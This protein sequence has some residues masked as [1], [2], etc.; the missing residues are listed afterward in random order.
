MA[1]NFIRIAT[2]M[3]RAARD[4]A[5]RHAIGWCLTLAVLSYGCV[6]AAHRPA[7]SSFR[8]EWLWNANDAIRAN[9]YLYFRKSITLETN[10]RS[11]LVHITADSRYKLYVNGHFVGR[12]PVRSDQRRQYYDSYDLA[13]FLKKGENVIAAIIHQYGVATGSY[14]LG[15]GGFWLQG[16]IRDTNDRVVRVDTD[17]SW[18]VL[19]ATAWEP[20]V[21]QISPAI[22]WMEIYDAR[23][24]P[25]GWQRPGYDDTHWQ[26][27]K[28]LGKPPV[29]P[30]KE[31]VPRDIPLL[32]EEERF[33]T[34]VLDVG[35]V[36][37]APQSATLRL[38][39]IF[40]TANG[41][42]AY[43]LSYLY[44]SVDQQ[45]SLSVHGSRVPAS[46][47]VWVN[48]FP[49][50]QQ[51]PSGNPAYRA[52][53][54]FALK[55]G[56]NEV[57]IKVYRDNPE[58]VVT[59]TLGP[60]DGRTFHPVQWYSEPRLGSP[61]NLI[62]IAGP[63]GNPGDPT[64]VITEI[65]QRTLSQSPRTHPELPGRV[66]SLSFS[67]NKN[68]AVLMA[69]ETRRSGSQSRVHDVDK[70]LAVNDGAASLSALDHKEGVYLTLDFGKEIS[71]YV[72]LRMKGVS[73][74]I[75]DLGYSEALLNGHVDTL[76]GELPW[77]FAD[78]Y[79]MR[80]G[81]QEWEL[82]FWKG[83]RYLQ[84]TFRQLER[85]IEIESVSLLFTSY[86]VHYR[87][88]FES[89]DSLLNQI[90]E[91]GRWTLQLCMHDAYED[92]PWREQSQWVGDAQVE[93][94]ANY[95]TFGDVALGSKYLRQIAQGQA[96]DGKLPAAYPAGRS[97]YP[98]AQA[99]EAEATIPAFM[100][101]WVSTLLNHY[102]YTG[103]RDL[104]LEL[105]PHVSR[106]IAYFDRYR[107][108]HGLLSDVPGFN[109]LDWYPG[110]DPS[111]LR[112]EGEVTGLNAHYYKALLDA[113]ALADVVADQSKQE[114][115]LSKAHLVKHAINERLWSERKQA[116][117][118]ARRGDELAEQVFVHDSVLAAYAGVA[119][120]ER[121]NRS[122][123]ILFDAPE[124]G[125]VQ[126]GTPYFYF[127]YLE[128][129]QRADR[130]QEALEVIREAYGRMLA[131][132]ATTWWEHL[133]GHASRS[134]A[135]SSGPNVDLSTYVLGVQPTEPA[136]AAFRVRPE[137]GDIQWAKGIVP[138]V[139]G[140]IRVEWHRPP[141]GFDLQ[142]SVPMKAR[143][144][145]SLPA[146]SLDAT[147]LTGDSPPKQAH[148]AG[149]RAYYHVNGPGVFRLRSTL[150]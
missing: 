110:L 145:L 97:V 39:D 18:R 11:A 125:T 51:V 129:L 139:R 2:I 22:M 78:R 118:H 12:G 87:G 77:N 65:E 93:L 114:E 64:D 5:A 149:G 119:P 25:A 150:P 66:I 111:A 34:A 99:L 10:P 128:A 52:L 121:V 32:L 19:P 86:P 133:S 81:P 48:G 20:D 55:R 21:P 140:D 120:S 67:P 60:A 24:E 105:Y 68:V 143:V 137:P 45:V 98:M 23:K 17:N 27:P 37:P 72:R 109:F 33:P 92:T 76:R 38:G 40:G 26:R 127:F 107:D 35:S 147:N 124:A 41:R 9:V 3:T 30:W 50:A 136:F 83:F 31:L 96:P 57:L 15:R 116:Y 63:Y 8:A 58:W 88:S 69:M 113:A 70:L 62:R 141:S 29:L 144:E 106:V 1:Q 28:I 46:Y 13:R 102:F 14:T 44:S 112:R 53:P 131:A 100:L 135:W 6:I 115:W 7:G 134:H 4:G 43:L 138:T 54:E 74:G 146:V 101:Q 59:L 79:I 122:F 91:T 56:W 89:S 47:Q 142:V 148:F 90:W 95:R 84:L 73:G 85:P 132:G 126:I 104:V 75:V 71:G 108:A 103:N 117:V 16:D 82:F 94:L 123:A 49:Y 80:E 61:R 130:H 42:I 36:D